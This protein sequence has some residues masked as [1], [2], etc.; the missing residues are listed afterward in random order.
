MNKLQ[1]SARMKIRAG[2]LEEFDR[3][4]EKTGIHAGEK[5][6]GIAIGKGDLQ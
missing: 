1:I 3:I 5:P 2:K 6:A 4:E